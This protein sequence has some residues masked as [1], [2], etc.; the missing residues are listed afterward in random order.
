[1]K[2]GKFE[3]KSDVEVMKEVLLAHNKDMDLKE[4]SEE[5]IKARFDAIAETKGVTVGNPKETAK[6]DGGT[7][8]NS[9]V[10]A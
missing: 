10:L 6:D 7:G 1:M 9:P 2:D 3:G 8:A 4:K 5:Y